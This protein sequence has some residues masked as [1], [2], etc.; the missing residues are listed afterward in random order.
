MVYGQRIS[1][2]IAGWKM[3]KAIKGKWLK[4]LRSGRIRQAHGVLL[5]E[6]GHMCCLG[7]LATVQGCDLKKM[8]DECPEN[9]ISDEP[10]KGY[11]ARLRLATC[12]RLAQ[13][14]DGN[15]DQKQHSFKEIADYIEKKL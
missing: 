13:M 14:N 8:R 3:E 2:K 12:E 6:R 1:N 7:V 11:K 10:P 4:A 9:M 5:D 15:G